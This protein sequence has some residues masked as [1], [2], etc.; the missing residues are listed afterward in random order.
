[1]IDADHAVVFTGVAFVRGDQFAGSIPIVWSVEGG[2]RLRNGCIRGLIG[3]ATHPL[4]SG[5]LQA[6]GLRRG[7][8]ETLGRGHRVPS[9]LQSSPVLAEI[10]H[11]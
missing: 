11:S 10:P 2:G 4:G 9:Q 7:W 8:Q 6:D 3:T 5:V 1:M